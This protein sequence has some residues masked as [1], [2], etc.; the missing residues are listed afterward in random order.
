[1]GKI[2]IKDIY[3]PIKNELLQ[4]EFELTKVVNSFDTDLRNDE[5]RHPF[6]VRGKMLRPA[7]LALSA[8][9][10]NEALINASN[11]KLIRL[12]VAL[13]LIHNASLIHDDI[14]DEDKLRRGQKTLNNLYG[15]KIAVL[16]GDAINA[17][18][19]HII[20]SLNEQELQISTVELIE[21][22]SLAEILQ[23][24]NNYSPEKK[25]YLQVIK[26]KTAMFMETCCGFGAI[27]SN[28]T[29]Q[30][31]LNLREF[32]MNLGMAYQIVDDVIDNDPVARRFI[33]FQDAVGYSDLCRKS[34]DGLKDNIYKQKLLDFVDLILQYPNQYELLAQKKQVV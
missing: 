26:A 28:G 5:F 6:K 2:S 33:T 17:R 16:V 11:D 19:F 9:F 15:N 24:K 25:K 30:E 23:I 21:K 10:V 31:I 22:M 12:G 20:S 34:L 27:I 8:K 3:Y 18:A 32:G 7:L 1:M 13:E 14:I 29:K 4:I